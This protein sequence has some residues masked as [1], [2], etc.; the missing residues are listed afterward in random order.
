V[1]LTHSLTVCER[2]N[3]YR[4][5]G[6]DPD[7]FDEEVMRQTNRTAR[8]AFPVVFQLTPAYFELRDQ[9][10]DT[11]RQIKAA[12]AQPLRQLGLKVRFAS[13][14]L[15]QFLQPMQRSDV[16]RAEVAA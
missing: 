1:F 6:M 4:L 14:L 7:R 8:R 3:F 13:L 12:Q 9:L 11:F 10:V 2:G 5:L 15:R 16:Q